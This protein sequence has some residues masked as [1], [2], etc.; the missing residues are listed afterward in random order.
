[1][2]NTG[3]GVDARTSDSVPIVSWLWLLPAF[4]TLGA[5]AVLAAGLRRVAAE[6]SALRSSLAA[7]D[8]LAVAMADLE[9]QANDVGRELRRV[10]RR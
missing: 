2:T 8:R 1:M 7:W 4:C 9:H 6:A 10:G 5:L 3:H